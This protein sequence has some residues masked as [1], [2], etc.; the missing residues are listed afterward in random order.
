[1][2]QKNLLLFALVSLL[3]LGLFYTMKQNAEQA[4]REQR[5]LL[6]TFEKEAT[7]IGMLKKRFSDK[8][9]KQRTLLALKRI[10]TPQKEF[11]KGNLK[12][13]LFDQL[14]A[15]KLNALLR[16]IANSGLQIKR[17]LISRIDDLHAKVRLEIAK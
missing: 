12:I 3:L 8:K 10:A 6:H 7:E 5:V 1:M 11:V 16:K 2:S 17:L 15:G 9:A 13:I 4:F 14:D